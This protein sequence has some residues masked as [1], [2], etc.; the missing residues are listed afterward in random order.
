[1]LFPLNWKNIK[2][3][4]LKKDTEDYILT[5]TSRGLGK[6][7]K[8]SDYRITKRNASGVKNYKSKKNESIINCLLVKL[9]DQIIIYTDKGSINYIS[10]SDIRI[11]KRT[12][13][14]V[15]LRHQDNQRIIAVEKIG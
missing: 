7:S 10:L 14:G 8:I 2:K 5:V 11:T 6:I 1:M 13:Q 4:T 3:W 15:Q 9:N 12:S